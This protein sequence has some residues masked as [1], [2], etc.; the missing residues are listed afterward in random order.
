MKT[1]TAIDRELKLKKKELKD[2]KKNGNFQT[3]YKY[4][5]IHCVFL[6]VR[7]SN[8]YKF[9]ILQNS[10][11]LAHTHAHTHIISCHNIFA[12]NRNST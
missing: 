9:L 4:C 2:E 1:T 7:I 10:E 5:C 3:F 12:G 8:L 6:T 11:E